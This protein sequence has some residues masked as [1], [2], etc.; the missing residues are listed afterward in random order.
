[1]TSASIGFPLETMVIF[2]SCVIFSVYMDLFAHRKSAEISVKD[3][4]LWSLFWIG[5]SLCFYGY[6]HVRHGSHAASLFLAGYFLE[7]SL[8]VDNLMVFIAIFS[9]F[10]I[11]GAL[12]H[13]ILYL[14][15]VGAVVFRLIFVLAG[16]TIAL[17]GPYA[18]I[19][20]GVVVGWSAYK[21]LQA[22]GDDGEAETDYSGHKIVKL[23]N[24][25][26]PVLAVLHGKRFFVS[27]SEANSIVAEH[28]LPKLIAGAKRY[29]TP[30]LVCLMV[31]EASDVMFSFDSVPAVIA[32]TRDP[33][34]IYAAMI[35][36]I[37]GLRSLYF[38]LA[39]MTKY[40]VHLS[41]AVITL[42]FFIT[43]KLFL[44]AAHEFHLTDFD[45]GP[46]ESLLIIGI[47]LGLGVLASVVLPGPTGG[48]PAQPGAST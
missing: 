29:A 1:M 16:S 30:A 9:Y 32:L 38:L 20:F 31:I 13:R 45:L 47:V 40:L 35:F 25:L 41:K 2:I 5:L 39:A 6:L 27:E 44:H 36:A 7:K 8:S 17:L 23:A 18:D 46:N 28:N 19:I 3:A 33:M 43:L 42:L 15:I 12:Q 14:G 24:G 37:L 26:F 11:S 22:G 10:R 4:G 21:M 34:L 48:E